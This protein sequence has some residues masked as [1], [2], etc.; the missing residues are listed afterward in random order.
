MIPTQGQSGIGRSVGSASA[1]R[2]M[3]GRSFGRSAGDSRSLRCGCRERRRPHLPRRAGRRRPAGACVARLGAARRGHRRR[4]HRGGGTNRPL[5][6]RRVA[7]RVPRRRIDG[8]V[9]PNAPADDVD[10]RVRSRGG[11]GH[12]RGRGRHRHAARVGHDGRRPGASLCPLPLGLRARHRG[13][14]TRDAGRG[15]DR[16]HHR[17]R[18]RRRSDRRIH[19]PPPRGGDRRDGPLPQ[20]GTG[21]RAGAGE[22]ARTRTTRSRA[23]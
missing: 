3:D 21:T 22:A 16:H 8:P 4:C 11:A 9:A 5:L 2:P 6:A 14:R 1:L 7:D 19:G 23:P 18:H 10:D 20:H 17:P 13:R 12:R 15:G